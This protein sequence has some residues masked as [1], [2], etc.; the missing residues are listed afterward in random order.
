MA[1]GETRTYE[2]RAAVPLRENTLTWTGTKPTPA[3]GGQAAN[4]DNNS[5]KETRDGESVLTYSEATGSY[6][7]ETAVSAGNHLQRTAKD[8]TTE[9]S[10]SLSTLAEGQVTEWRILVHSSEYRYNTTVRVEDELP[11]GLCPLSSTNLTS[12]SECA[13]NGDLPSSPYESAVEEANGTWKLVWTEAT[14]AALANLQQNETTTI[15]FFSRERSHYQS[16]H[17]P[18]TPVLANDVF[19]NHVLSSSTT[20]VVCGNDSDCSGGQ[21]TPIDHERP[22]SEA[23]SDTSA[24]SQTA[25]GPTIAKKVAQSGSECLADTFVTSI[26]VYHPGDTVCWLLEASFP[27]QLSTHGSGITDFLPASV[28]F[29]ESF[30]S[31]RGEA[32]EPSDSLPGTTFS[33]T[34]ASS[35]SPGGDVSWALPEEGFVGT[36]GQHFARVIATT[37]TLK[38]GAAPGDLQGNLMKFS[39]INTE[40]H[41]FALREEANFKLEFPEL[42]LAKDVIAVDK[43]AIT[44][45]TSAKIK[46]GDEAEFALK[47]TN[48]G[49]QQALKS[50]VWEEL[51]SSISCS[52]VSEVSA[53][54]SCVS[55]RITWGD[56]GLGQPEVAVPSKGETT[57]TFVVTVP[58]TINPATTLEDKAGIVEYHSPTNTGGEYT[59][60]PAEDIDSTLGLEANVPAAAAHADLESEE[61]KLE[62]THT[63]AVTETGNSASQ[64]TIGELVTFEVTATLPAGTSFGGEAQIIDPGPPVARL[65]YEKGSAEALLE[66]AAAPPEFKISE[67]GGLPVLTMPANYTAPGT[68]ARKVTLRFKARVANASGNYAGG[69]SGENSIPNTGKLTW[70][71][72]ITGA[73]S[74][75]AKDSVPLVEPQ[76]KL[77]QSN[78]AGGPV[79]GGQLVEYKLELSNGASASSAF[80]NKIV[81]TLPTNVTLTNSGGTAL[82]NGESTAS[83]GVY[84]EAARTVTWETAKLATNGKV[85]FPFF[86]TVNESPVS[87]SSLTNRALATTSSIEGAAEVERTAADAPTAPSKARYESLTE[88]ALEVE[89]ATIAKESDSAKAT[90]GHRIAYTLTITLPPHVTAFEETAI[91][92]LPDSLDFDEYVGSEC[93][94]GCPPEAAPTVG[95]YEPVIEATGTKLAWDLGNLTN[96]SVARTV[97]IHYVASVR[98]T[99]RSGGKPVE[100]P[101]SF[102]NQAVLYYNQTEKGPFEASKF[103]STASFDK[104]TGPVAAR[105]TVVEPHLSLA[106]EVSV[107]GGAYGSAKVTLTDGDTLAYR[108]TV[109]NT[110]TSPAYD[111]VVVDKP[112]A[113]LEAITPSEESGDVT[114]NTAGELAWLIPGPIAAGASVKLGYTAR[115]VPVAQLKAGETVDNEASQPSYFGASEAERGEH[116]KNFA[117]E[118]IAYREYSGGTAQVAAAVA[119]PT[120]TIEKTTGAAGFPTTANAEVGQPFKWRVVV[121]NTSSV[122]AKHLT[123]TDHLP[124]NWEYVA[125]SASFSSGGAIEPTSAGKAE[126]GLELM[127]GTGIELAAGAT[128]TLSYEAKPTVAAETTP[129]SGASHPNN[130]SAG[131][132][133]QDAAGH[134]EDAEG[135]FA[136]GPSVAHA[137]L[138]LPGLE[139]T[140]VPAKATVDSGEADSYTIT[141]KN[142]GS[143]PAREVAIADTLPAGMTYTAKTATASPSTGFS[144][145]S[146]T[147]SG[148][149]WKIESI[150]TGGTVKVTVPVGTEA[151]VAAGTKL[152]NQVAVSSLEVT[153]PVDASGTVETET[154]ADLAAT[155]S[156]AAGASTIPG[157]Q[158]TYRLAATN[159]GPSLAHSVVLTDTLP[160]GETY[161]S[162]P[163]GCSV[164][165]GTVT[166]ERAE[167][168][169]GATASYE[170]VVAIASSVTGTIENSV[171]VTSA[172]K[173]PKPSDNTA[174]V[175]SEAHPSADLALVKTTLTPEVLDGQAARFRLTATNEG[176]SDA[177][178]AKILDTLPA[179]LTYTSASGASCVAT[180]Q[181]VTCT[182]G[183]LA[184]TASHSVEI[185]VAEAGPG[186]Y[187]NEASVSSE[188]PDPNPA[189]NA[190][191]AGLVVLPAATLT[192]EKTAEAA[193]VEVPG[194]VTYALTVHNH[195][196][197]AAQAVV[198]TDTLPVGESYVS[199]DAGCSHAG[200]TVT[201]ALGELAD[202]AAHTVHLVTEVSVALGAQKVTNHATVTS[203]TGDPEPGGTSAEASVQAGPAADV[204]IVKSA[205]ATVQSGGQITW[206]LHVSNN[207]PSTASGVT[208][209]DSLPSG[210]ALVSAEPSQGSCT[211]AL[212][213][214][215]CELGILAAGAG[216]QVTIHAN[217]LAGPGAIANTATVRA[218]QPDPEPANNSS[219]VSSDVLPNPDSGVQPSTS[220]QFRTH[221]TL[222]KRASA[223][224][225]SDGARV[226]Y[227]LTIVNVGPQAAEQVSLCD[228]LP[229]HTTVVDARGG[230]LSDGRICFALPLLAP[231]AQ[232]VYVLTLRIDSN[233][234]GR[235]VNHATAQGADFPT[236]SASAATRVRARVI[237]RREHGVTG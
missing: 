192:L 29:N 174:S 26:P 36:E 158:I 102:E 33:H 7:N 232:H 111:A 176:P 57:L 58:S 203:T 28:T 196:P 212:G 167:L 165:A 14:D 225:A 37:A 44:P 125:H 25:E 24:A 178:E 173:D 68:G 56:T 118:A 32:A 49:E 71:N 198:V 8:I 235:I 189:N 15:T 98:A 128:D 181:Q 95:F 89:G 190:S 65:P 130:N 214:L 154:S 122:P 206:V 153:T 166:C 100:A 140:K 105:T 139:V 221:V 229:A 157:G 152:T 43:K 79:H 74:K 213:V 211:S 136:A 94:S 156:I 121:K 204:A 137:I 72:P 187:L 200:Q 113:A 185:T 172:T 210:S 112:P 87:A 234:R 163:A 219:S 64:A 86:V 101:A 146:A 138:I 151:G 80:D 161:V 143:A 201:C 220:T 45:A 82:K 88:A 162:G 2:F 114:K 228:R 205:P 233:A 119:L 117:K 23:I 60:V 216:A 160:A 194:K 40:G 195:G 12:S 116:L 142:T 92:T 11:N 164:A 83:G 169:S 85:T 54:G 35:S 107:D 38:K 148:M 124:A 84:N 215:T 123:V 99:H 22:L 144:E 34:E 19:T 184:A 141:V 222:A 48:A 17:K 61:A 182:L 180:G 31:G 224:V 183:S 199:D 93:T 131:A 202:G 52:A 39:S 10:A 110:G 109:T 30:N 135:P 231:H 147:S 134:S 96:T 104:K 106:K 120:I 126:T 27:Q 76:I 230:H 73:Q 155:K 20:N 63:T 208:T 21:K 132:S 209:S 149:S 108:L 59:Y 70:T 5:G 170:I 47:L 50:E 177:A 90:I 1:P 46:G 55:G 217:V 145:T 159:N 236:V 51:P 4:L 223:R 66:G 77:L 133:V 115:L 191:D 75:E 97:K 6:K 227:R 186:R 129:G 67:V 179:G 42:S 41:S 188:T 62:K 81:D 53:G 226:R 18:T 78:N 16:A 171:H 197:D 207:G 150:A 69:S 13:P 3:S 237:A 91:D 9:K 218:A 103:P 127:W 193:T 168:A 175:S